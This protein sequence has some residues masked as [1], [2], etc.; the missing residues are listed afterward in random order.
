M[1]IELSGFLRLWYKK[2]RKRKCVMLPSLGTCLVRAGRRCK[3][4]LYRKLCSLLPVL[5]KNDLLMDKL[6]YAYIN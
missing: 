1:V 5:N 4:V 2:T 3:Q 6:T